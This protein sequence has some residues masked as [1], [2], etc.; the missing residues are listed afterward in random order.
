MARLRHFAVCVRDL[1]KSAEFYE[2]VF[3]L[4]NVGREDLPIGSAVY[5]SDGVVNLALIKFKGADANDLADP[6]NA[7][8]S[9]HFGFQVEDMA[10]TQRR[11][12][13]AGGRFFFDL[14]DEK[15]GN[16]E[17]KFRDPDGIIFDISKHGWLGT[18]S[19]TDPA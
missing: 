15:E 3:E 4:K 10:E 17:R 16:F 1:D 11:I 18:D 7:V 6:R 12:E 8:G 14:G 2:Q 9:N 5:L 19:R 13:A